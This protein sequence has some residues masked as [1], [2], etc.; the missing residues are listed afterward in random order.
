M[1]HD[2]ELESHPTQVSYDAGVKFAKKQPNAHDYQVN[3][4]AREQE[5]T[6]AFRDGYYNTVNK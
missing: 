5:D 2:D 3:A 6:E 4:E 1:N